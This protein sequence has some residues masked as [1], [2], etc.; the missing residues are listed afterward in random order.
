[1]G[2][3]RRA[4]SHL[5]RLCPQNRT[6]HTDHSTSNHQPTAPGA[7]CHPHHSAATAAKQPLH[8][9]ATEEQIEATPPGT[10]AHRNYVSPSGRAERSNHAHPALIYLAATIK[11]GNLMIERALT[12]TI[13]HI[14]PPLAKADTFRWIL[15]PPEAPFNRWW[16][17]GSPASPVIGAR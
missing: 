1:M 10:L 11:E 3:V 16:F 12:N 7:T 14:V 9:T 5:S 15:R 13:A 4:W 17:M 8:E 2:K 6:E